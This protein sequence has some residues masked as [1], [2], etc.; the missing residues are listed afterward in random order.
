MWYLNK[1]FIGGSPHSIENFAGSD[2]KSLFDKNLL[3]KPDDWYYRNK[4]LTYEFN[5]LGHRCKNTYDIDLSNYILF[6]GC[7]HTMG[8]GNALEDTFPYLVSKKLNID[9]YNLGIGAAGPDSMFHNLVTWMNKFSQKPKHI[10]WQWPDLARYATVTKDNRVKMHGIWEK[11]PEVV[12]FMVMGH[13]NDFH[14]SRMKLI[15]A[16][17]DQL[18]V[19]ITYVST[20]AKNKDDP[21]NTVYYRWIDKDNARDNMHMGIK[22]NELLA[23]HLAERLR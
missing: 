4:P 5:N 19:P 13:C 6:F 10:I 16:Y 17:L 2:E 7:S 22:S 8:I 3:T 18:N 1:G 23:N 12:N 21:S 15:I 20:D 9:Y 14:I 11:D